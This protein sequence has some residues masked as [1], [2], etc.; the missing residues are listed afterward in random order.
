MGDAEWS[1]SGAD[2]DRNMQGI[3]DIHLSVNF[4]PEK[5]LTIAFP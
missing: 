5:E 4:V 1:E 2:L 3:K